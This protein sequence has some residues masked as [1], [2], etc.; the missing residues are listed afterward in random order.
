MTAETH[1]SGRTSR[2][3]DTTYSILIGLTSL[4]IL[5]QGVWAGIFVREGKDNND[6]WVTVHARGADI[7][8]LLAIASVVVAFI[9]LRARR[10]LLLGTVAL[11]VLL[12]VEAY[13][14]GLIG[15]SPAVE[16][17]HFPLAMLLLALAVYLPLRARSAART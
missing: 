7:A 12:V 11:A 1:H 10:D 4:A 17:V 8:I 15:N 3:H 13:L 6:T 9:R 14:G 2:V 5:L 16:I